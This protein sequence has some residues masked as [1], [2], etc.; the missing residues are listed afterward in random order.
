MQIHDETYEKIRESWYR[1]S[2]IA[3][4]QLYFPTIY[5][6]NRS[7]QKGAILWRS[8]IKIYVILNTFYSKSTKSLF[9]STKTPFYHKG[10]II[11]QP[12][13][14]RFIKQKTWNK[15]RGNRQRTAINRNKIWSEWWKPAN[16][17][18]FFFYDA[19]RK[20]WKF[21]ERIVKS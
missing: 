15:N 13:G 7:G 6:I 10:H 11:L 20:S 8:Y 17:G 9:R 19:K 5:H 12:L 3:H 1:W 4:K 16:Q 2:R 14:F 21:N 18:I